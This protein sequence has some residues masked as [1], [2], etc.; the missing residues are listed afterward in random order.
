MKWAA[1]RLVGAEDA[2]PRPLDVV[3]P[4]SDRVGG[5]A[6]RRTAAAHVLAD[7]GAR[8]IARNRHAHRDVTGELEAADGGV[9]GKVPTRPHG[10]TIEPLVG[11]VLDHVAEEALHRVRG[12]DR[13]LRE[14]E[15]EV[16]DHRGRVP[17]ELARGRP[18][19]RHAAGK[20]G[21][22][23]LRVD[24]REAAEEP[25]NPLVVEVPGHLAGEV[26]LHHPM[27][28]VRHGS[29]LGEA[30]RGVPRTFRNHSEFRLARR[31]GPVGL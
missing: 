16:V 3:H 22:Q 4:E 13:R 24:A 11:C 31:G 26:G 14:A 1:W 19:D 5:H 17:H 15:L 6:E 23:R 20:A 7:A 10:R 8:L 27:H 12:H 25:G 9:L 28:A 29:M 30:P 21:R 2:H 18:D